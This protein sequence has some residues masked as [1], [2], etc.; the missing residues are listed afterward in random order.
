MPKHVL[1]NAAVKIG[2]VDLSD[3]VRSATVS[4]NF[5]QVDVSGM[6]DTARQT[7]L[8]LSDDQFQVDFL[9]DYDSAKVDETLWPL[10]GG[11]VFNVEVWPSG[12]TTSATNPKFS[13]S[14]IL[15]NYS[16]IAGAFGAAN[17]TSVTFKTNGTA[18]GRATA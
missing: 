11:S 14:C 13:A 17:E 18:I 2:G 15:V 3:H 16:P 8:G 9:Q 4:R 12:T 5:D 7:A 10:V 1:K 6:G